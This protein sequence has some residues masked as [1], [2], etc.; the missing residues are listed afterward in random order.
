MPTSRPR[1]SLRPASVERPEPDGAPVS[2][3]DLLHAFVSDPRLGALELKDV[4]SD[5]EGRR[6]SK[7]VRAEDRC[8]ATV[9]WGLVRIL[10]GLRTGTEPG[11]VPFCRN[12]HGKP[13]VPGGP[14]FNMAHSGPSI[15]IGISDAGRLG[16]DIEARRPIANLERLAEDV[17]GDEELAQLRALPP[18]EQEAAFYRGWTRKE[19]FVKAVGRGLSMPLH[20][21]VVSL[22][23]VWGSVLR[24][25]DGAESVSHGWLV[26]SVPVPADAEAAIAF[27]R[28]AAQVDWMDL[29]DLVR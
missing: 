16:V 17:F 11:A 28:E 1:C 12:A 14:S 5:A 8:R 24:S 10:V 22:A 27:D 19:A 9:A 4:L 7:L 13:F 21:L 2:K 15:L 23:P 20:S 3:I 29:V 18:T 26:R 25:V 6:I